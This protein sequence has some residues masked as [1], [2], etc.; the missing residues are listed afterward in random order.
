MQVRAMAALAEP[1][2]ER[3]VEGEGE[4]LELGL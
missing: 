2:G 4:Q 1:V 3:T